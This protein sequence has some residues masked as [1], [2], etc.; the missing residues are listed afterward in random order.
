MLPLLQ[1]LL[2]QDA[3]ANLTSEVSCMQ[4]AFLNKSQVHMMPTEAEEEH[5]SQALE[6]RYY[7]TVAIAERIR[8]KA[9]KMKLESRKRDTLSNVGRITLFLLQR[10]LEALGDLRVQGSTPIYLL[11]VMSY[12]HQ[13]L[14]RKELL[15]WLRMQRVCFV[16]PEV[17]VI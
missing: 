16:V 4:Q 5:F 17:E 2:V 3:K 10:G 7:L 13:I 6:I 9:I 8:E 14:L 1:L 12:V 11:P 15:E